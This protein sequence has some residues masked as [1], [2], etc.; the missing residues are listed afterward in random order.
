MTPGADGIAAEVRDA[1]GRVLVRLEGYRTIELPGVLDG[2]ALAPIRA[3]M[4]E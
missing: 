3:A 4:Q 1:Q 2:D